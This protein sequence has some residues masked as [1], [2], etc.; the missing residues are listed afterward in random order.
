MDVKKMVEQAKG[1]VDI[2]LL[3][4]S[5]T[6]GILSWGYFGDG[7]VTD[8]LRSGEQVEY[9]L[10]NLTKG[11]VAR[12]EDTEETIDSD[13]ILRTALLVTDV[14]LLYI[15]GKYDG[16]EVFSVPL[17]ECV[18]VSVSTGLLKN[19][20]TVH[21]ESVT[22]D[23]YVQKGPDVHAIADY[24]ETAST[25][26]SA[27]TGTDSGRQ[28]GS[29]DLFLSNAATHNTQDGEQKDG[30]TPI[31][32]AKRDG[33]V[34]ETGGAVLEILVSDQDGVPVDGATVNLIGSTFEASGRTSETGRCDLTLPATRDTARLTIDHPEFTSTDAEVPVSDGA[35]FDVALEPEEDGDADTSSGEHTETSVDAD[36][37]AP[38][39]T[40]EGLLEELTRLNERCPKQITRGRMRSDGKFDPEDY[41]DEF[42]TWSAA[43]EEATFSDDNDEEKLVNRGDQQE[44]YTKEE[45]VDAI[46]DVL[47]RVDGRPSTTE[48][49][50]YGEMSPSPA[51]RYFDTWSDAVDAAEKRVGY[52]SQIPTDAAYTKDDVV[53]EI[54]EVASRLGRRPDTTDFQEHAQM[55]TSPVFRYFDTWDDAVATALGESS[56]AVSEDSDTDEKVDGDDDPVDRYAAEGSASA[57]TGVKWAGSTEGP[58]AG[59]IEEVSEGRLSNAVVRIVQEKES[60]GTKRE[61]VVEVR[62]AVGEHLDLTLWKKHDVNFEFEAGDTVRLDKVRLKRWNG[63]G[64]YEHALSS[65]RDLS[66]TLVEDG[67]SSGSSPSQD[68][69]DGD[70]QKEAVLDRFL[71]IG[72]AT[73][74]DAEALFEAGYSTKDDL[75]AA[76][77]EELRSVDGLDDGT[78]LRMKAEFG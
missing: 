74:S 72:G 54:G 71:G 25:P 6:G 19:R 14:R 59:D 63:N 41:E 55:S 5:R 24:L 45:V 39:V 66:A 43:L 52:R 57:D 35:V 40:R 33:G 67:K 48:M 75:K 2:N 78:A 32:E 8:R 31:P 49:N 11:L 60:A 68:G 65:T 70:E 34:S 15:V 64:G 42:G 76:S 29:E 12:K 62:T 7:L 13:M 50:K 22:Y 4:G 16:D 37:N 21:A 51:Y 27:P 3:K 38:A 20:F 26:D 17:K 73:E 58:L 10:Q 23:M 61:A 69:E 46:N 30:G 18:D 9:T 56:A 28:A 36:G 47:E 77:L 53:E 44:T 1:D